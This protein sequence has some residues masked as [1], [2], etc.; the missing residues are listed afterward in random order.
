VLTAWLTLEE[1]EA[2]TGRDEAEIYIAMRRGRVRSARLA[3][4][5]WRVDAAAVMVWAAG[6]QSPALN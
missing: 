4:S 1:A 6:L 2:L 5:S 3:D